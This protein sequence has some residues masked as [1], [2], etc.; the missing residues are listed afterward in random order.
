MRLRPFIAERPL[1]FNYRGLAGHAWT[2]GDNVLGAMAPSLA[3]WFFGEGYTGP[4]FE[5]WLCVQNPGSQ[6]ANLRITYFTEGGSPLVRELEVPAASRLTVSVNSDAGAGLA[7]STLVE[8]DS[9]VIV[10]RPM[11]F[12]F[13]GRWSG[14]HT[15]LGYP[16]S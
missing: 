15:V 9:P 10:E 4:G 11:Y 6:V 2:G 13:G 1:Y 16:Q 3:D 8:S 14:G 12:D 5:Q 7:V